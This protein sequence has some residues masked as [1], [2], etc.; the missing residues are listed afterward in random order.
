MQCHRCTQSDLNHRFCK[1][2]VL[3]HLL[4]LDYLQDRAE[5]DAAPFEGAEQLVL[6]AWRGG[7]HARTL[8]ARN[9]LRVFR[10][11]TQYS[12]ECGIIRNGKKCRP[13]RVRRVG[14]AT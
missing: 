5:M 7:V 12:K 8:Y 14:M 2:T 13:R 4:E 3:T 6:Q 9:H 11:S 10:M 1:R